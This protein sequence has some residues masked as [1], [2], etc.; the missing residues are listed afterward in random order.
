MKIKQHVVIT[1]PA[2]FLKGDYY[3]C[4]TLFSSECNIDGWIEC[5]E[6]ELNIEVDSADVVRIVSDELDEQISKANAV[7]AVL[8]QK[9]A[10]L[11]AL[12]AP[13][14]KPYH[15]YDDYPEESETEIG[16]RENNILDAQERR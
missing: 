7:V 6:L 1:D 12:P 3:S 2:K 5:G 11:L 10:E 15:E 13:E 8:E 4:F 16:D 9:K 14:V